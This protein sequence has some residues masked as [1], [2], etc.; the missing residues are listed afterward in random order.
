MRINEKTYSPYWLHT[1]EKICPQSSIDEWAGIDFLK[2]AKAAENGDK[3]ARQAIFWQMKDIIEAF[4]AKHKSK[5]YAWSNPLGLTEKGEVNEMALNWISVSWTAIFDGYPLSDSNTVGPFIKYVKPGKEL[6]YLTWVYYKKIQNLLYA[7]HA[8]DKSTGLTILD[9][10][11][12][13][14]SA[15]QYADRKK[16]SGGKNSLKREIMDQWESENDI[17]EEEFALIDNLR[18]FKAF[19]RDPELNE[20]KHGFSP[21]IAFKAIVLNAAKGEDAESNMANIAAN[22]NISRN[23]FAAYAQKA[24]DTLRDKYD[25]SLSE[26]QSLLRRYGPESLGRLIQESKF[27]PKPLNKLFEKCNFKLLESLFTGKAILNESDESIYDAHAKYEKDVEQKKEEDDNQEN[28]KFDEGSVK[29]TTVKESESIS[30]AHEE[31]KK[32]QESKKEDD[33]N[34]ENFTFDEGSVK[35][36]TVK[37]GA[38]KYYIRME[39]AEGDD[40]W[41]DIYGPFTAERAEQEYNSMRKEFAYA[42]SQGC[43]EV[44]YCD[45][46]GDYTKPPLKESRGTY[47]GNI[48]ECPCCGHTIRQDQYEDYTCEECGEIWEDDDLDWHPDGDEYEDGYDN[49]EVFD[50]LDEST[51]L[52][53]HENPFAKIAAELCRRFTKD[54]DFDNDDNAMGEAADRLVE[55]IDS[56]IEQ[57][58]EYFPVDVYEPDLYKIWEEHEKRHK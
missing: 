28:F 8:L 43:A 6:S 11:A 15:N 14:V 57:S 58:M 21:M 18:A 17:P 35:L 39:Y 32:D 4:Y 46:N 38:R 54:I 34:Q 30:K 10:K 23:T 33:D 52:K 36:T 48:A 49:R 37:E 13:T 29:L 26:L 51:N 41:D 25:V 24:A 20:K 7:D 2:V 9:G 16:D 22:Y 12:D 1:F 45:A 19:A 53:E 42:I 40:A 27:M 50:P 47:T 3:T 5:I 31:F 56:L 44:Y 55:F